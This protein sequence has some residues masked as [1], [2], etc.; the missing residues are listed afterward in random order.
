MNNRKF[1]TGNSVT[2]HHD[3][4]TTTVFAIV[5]AVDRDDAV[6]KLRKKFPEQS[7]DSW[8]VGFDP[9]DG[10]DGI[11]WHKVGCYKNDE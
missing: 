2:C 7:P 10:N 9:K 6:A 1:F 4:Y 3:G 11:I 8:L 5:E